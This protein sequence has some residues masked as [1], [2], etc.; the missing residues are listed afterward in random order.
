MSEPTEADSGNSTPEGAL[1]L[2]DDRGGRYRTEGRKFKTPDVLPASGTFSLEEKL[3]YRLKNKVLGKPLVNEQL[4]SERLGRPTALAILSSDVM[5]SSA[6]ATEAMVTILIPVVGVAAFSLVIPITL[7]VLLVLA[8]V[9]ASYLQVIKAYPKA[10][11]AYIVTRENFGV[12][13]AQVAAAALLIDYTLTVAVSIAAGVDALTSAV[14]ALI[15]YN[16]ELSVFFVLLIALGNLRGIREAGKSFAVPTFIF[17][18]NMAVLI[19]LGIFR[20]LTVGLPAHSLHQPGAIAVGHPGTGLLVGA[21]LYIVLNAFSNGGT[22]LTGTEAISNGVSIF[23]SPQS[24]NA[25]KTLIAMSL[26]LGTMFFGVSLLDAITHAVPRISGS[27]TVVSQIATYVYGTGTV[28]RILYFVLQASTT[29]ILVLAANTSFTGFPF[30]ASFAAADSFLPR[31]FTRRGHRL[32]FSSGIIVLTVVSVI[33]LVATRARVTAL[34]ALYAIGV[35]TGFTLA[36]V[37]MVKHHLTEKNPGWRW[38]T[39][40]N[41][42]AAVLSFLVDIIFAVTKFKEG[43]WVV[44]VL[45]PL[46]VLIF[47]RLHRQYE[48]EDQELETGLASAMREKTLKHHTVF[49]FVDRLDLATVRAIQYSKTLNADEVRAVHF[50]LDDH[51]AAL[52]ESEWKSR[53]VGEL[54]LEIVECQDR[55]LRRGALEMVLEALSDHETEVTV[56]LPRRI[57]PSVFSRLLHDQTADSIANVVGQL[58]HSTATIVP[59]VVPRSRNDRVFFVPRRRESK[60]LLE[61]QEAMGEAVDQLEVLVPDSQ[62]IGSVTFRQRAKVAG[63]I[64]RIRVGS[65]DSVPFLTVRLEDSTGGIILVFSGRKS[66]PGISPGRRLIAEGMVGE[67][68]GHLAIL[69]PGYEFLASPD[70]D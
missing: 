36:G 9:T 68:G 35:F 59:F 52:L 69:N 56:L 64:A 20:Y 19:G 27:P 8:A 21:S 24:L 40:V 48:I 45:L 15:P 66:V 11:G 2:G 53:G 12:R 13:F 10:G 43:A 18:A 61:E 62:P 70:S 54:D 29:A 6:Y 34:I 44:V 50:Q 55:R 30:L 41:G 1:I 22:A 63:R 31:Q 28:G 60:D 7:G 3:S 38:R 23:R 39:A 47:L 32:V 67:F 14:P 4:G 46:L 26:I 42:A 57:Y 51:R 33:L 58:P 65:S 25:R 5:S 37:G 16:V 17:I 49:I